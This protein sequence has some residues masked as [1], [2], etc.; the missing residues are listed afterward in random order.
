MKTKAEQCKEE[1][2]KCVKE[3]KYTEAVFHYTEAIKHEPNTAVLYSNRS[4]AFL[5]I[6]QLFLAMEDAQKAIKLE[7]SWPKGYFR[8][9]EIEVKAGHYNKALVSYKQA[10]IRDP[11]IEG[12]AAAIAKTNK[13]IE[14]DKRDAT[15]KPIVYTCIGLA[16]GALIVAADQFVAVQPS[17]H[18]AILQVLIVVGCGGFGFISSKLQRYLAQSQRDALL[19][20]PIDLLSEINND[21][22]SPQSLKSSSVPSDRPNQEK[23]KQRKHKEKSK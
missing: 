14:K 21:T 22:D 7:P 4:L 5:K 9:A 18:Y 6:D 16:V 13:E 17:I 10:L 19:E 11:N 15:H 12:I 23:G 8:K 1:G 3:G 2:N 20:E